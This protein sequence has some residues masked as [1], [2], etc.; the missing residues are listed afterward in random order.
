[1]RRIARIGLPVALAATG[2][3]LGL[4]F[5]PRLAALALIVRVAKQEGPWARLARLTAQKVQDGP[6]FTIATRHG[7]MDA[8]LYRAHGPARRTT[9]L[10]PG[11]H[12]NGVYEARLVGLAKELAASGMQ[13]LTVAPPDLIRYRITPDSADALEDAVLWASARPDLAPDGRVGLIGI[14]FSGGL[15]VVAAG[16]ARAR[17]HVAFVLSFGGHGDLP[18]VLRYLCQGQSEALP[19]DAGALAVGGENIHLPKPHDYGGV[20]TLLNVAKQAVPAAQVDPLEQ[21][22]TVFLQ[23]S[24]I[25]RLDPVAARAVFAHARQLG[26]ALPEPARTLMTY[27]N[28]RDVAKVGQAVAAV[29]PHLEL[30]PA[31]SPERSPL[32]SAPVFLLHG[33]DDSV[34][35]ASEMLFLARQLRQTT[36]VR[37]M[38]S[39]L[40]THAEVNRS[41]AL[42]EMWRLSGFWQ[43]LLAR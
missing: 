42:A 32:P 17:D 11:V 5:L 39:R 41:A 40:I 6:V 43:D 7:A 26:Q 34:V 8:R 29:L 27:V 3:L 25:E 1:M 31:L 33:A 20:V 13:V 22:I 14:S 9:L 16:R 38:A 19:A 36:R 21:A 30:S 10:V 15:A 24:S 12:M 4:H 35:P 28:E 2:T 23:A 18:R 37:A